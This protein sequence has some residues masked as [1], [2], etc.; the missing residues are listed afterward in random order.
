MKSK[1]LWA[2]LLTLTLVAPGIAKSAN[3][4][5]TQKQKFSYTVGY[6]VG[7][8]FK[9]KGL[10]LDT[11]AFVQAIRDAQEGKKPKLDEQQMQQAMNT[12]KEALV[13][14]RK[15]IADTNL[16]LSKAFLDQNKTKKG[17][18]VTPSGLQ[19]EVLK[20]GTGAKP[21][22]SDTVE[23]HYHGTLIDG[24]V[25]DSSVNRG[26]T[27]S[28]PVNGV[29]KGWQEALQMMKKGAKW[30]VAIPPDLAYGPA[31]KPPVIAPNMALVF[32]IELIDI[33]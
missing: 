2:I 12:Y 30:R 20:A 3:V 32:E 27:V 29:I 9:R 26:Q 16:K 23:V 11:D 18:K 19:Y 1:L 33:K 31:G 13:A 6:Q 4:L 28:F 7:M 25:F 24:R 22:A 21:K 10:D 17:V 14:K 5:T 15:E 8:D